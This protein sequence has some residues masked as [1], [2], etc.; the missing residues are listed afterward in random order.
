MIAPPGSSQGLG[1]QRPERAW[2]GRHSGRSFR[3]SDRPGAAQAVYSLP[4]LQFISLCWLSRIVT[5]CRPFFWEQGSVQLRRVGPSLR[6]VLLW[7]SMD[8]RACRRRKLRRVGSVVA[9]PGL[10]SRGSGVVA[11]GLVAPR[12]LGSS[13]ARD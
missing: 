12:H 8:S 1:E 5:A 13:Q 7:Q 10:Q 3:V 9:S 2:T 6:C 4:I 11:T